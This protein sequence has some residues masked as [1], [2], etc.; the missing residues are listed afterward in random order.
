MVCARRAL[1]GRCDRRKIGQES[2]TER[3]ARLRENHEELVSRPDVLDAS[4]DTGFLNRYKN[5]VLTAAHVSLEWRIDFDQRRNPFCMERLWV[6]AVFNAG[7]IFNE[8]RHV[9]AARVEGYDRKSSF[10]VAESCTGV[11]QFRF[12]GEPLRIAENDPEETNW[13]DMRLTR[14]EDGWIYGTFCVERKD[15]AAP[16]SDNTQ[17]VASCGIVRTEDLRRWER[18]P[19]LVTPSPQ[20]RNVVL[21]PE[22]IHGRY[23][24]Y[25]RPTDHFISAGE[26]VGDVSDVLFSNGLTVNESGELFLYYASS[27]TR[28]HVATTT[29]E[30]LLDYTRHTPPDAGKSSACS[31]QRTDLI[32]KNLIK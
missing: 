17:A 18:L 28:L 5:P 21:H 12:C 6:N 25:T 7:A 14:H 31:Q 3:T 22:L 32:R 9:L 24:F 13:Y 11:D 29:V 23:M 15:P 19:D 16:E 1:N 2:F 10:A 20:Q 27:D 8:G 26:R 4:Y 30:A